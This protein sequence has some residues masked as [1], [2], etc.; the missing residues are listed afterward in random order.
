MNKR[1]LSIVCVLTLCLSQLPGA[2]LAQEADGLSTED[3]V[4]SSEELSSSG[5]DAISLDETAPSPEEVE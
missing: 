2:A 3:A 1:L 5:G 4:I